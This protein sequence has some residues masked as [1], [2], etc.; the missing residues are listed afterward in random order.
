M[1]NISFQLT[2]HVSLLIFYSIV[3][4]T[5]TAIK[6]CFLEVFFHKLSQDQVSCEVSSKYIYVTIPV[7]FLCYWKHDSLVEVY[8]HVPLEVLCCASTFKPG[9][10]LEIRHN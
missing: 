7:E 9:K 3:N 10:D 1:L 4:M 6:T 5:C 8:F 2:H